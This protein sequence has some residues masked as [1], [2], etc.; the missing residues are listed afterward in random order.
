MELDFSQEGRT[1]L[2]LACRRCE[3]SLISALLAAGASPVA[4][5]KVI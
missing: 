1:P 3:V 5:D 2:H 4:R